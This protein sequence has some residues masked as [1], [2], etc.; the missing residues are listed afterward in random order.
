[1]K[2]NW[3]PLLSTNFLGVLNDNLLKY[4]VV[5][6][7]IGWLHESNSSMIVAIA[8]AM[9]VLPYIFFSPLAGYL[10]MKYD[11]ARIFVIM[12]LIEIPIALIGAVGFYYQNLY[13][14]MAA[15]LLIGLQSAIYS[16]SKYGLIRDVGGF[17]GIPY[18]TG[19]MEMLTFAGV[20][21]G[22]VLA[23]LVSDHYS[24]WFAA[25]L[26]VGIAVTGY[27]TSLKIKVKES[28][29]VELSDSSKNPY[30]FGVHTFKWSESTKGL[31]LIVFALSTFWL[32]GSLLQMNLVVHCPEHLG[33]TNIETGIVMAAAAIGIGLGCY[34]TG[35]LSN[36]K[37]ELG[38][39]PVGSIGMILTLGYIYIFDPKGYLFI[40]LIFIAAFFTGLYKVP[41]NSWIQDRVK[42]RMLGDILA[43]CNLLDFVFILVSAGIFAL[44][45]MIF[46]TQTVFIF[47]IV[48][49][50]LITTILF[51]YLPEMSERFKNLL[52]KK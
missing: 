1:M 12:K 8:S 21:I 5:F 31:N 13:V 24:I 40:A 14:A 52:S 35:I 22:T 28:A 7:G 33:M 46:D 34:L 47:I 39:V 25:G 30:T 19:A 18:G 42:G 38:F 17:E 9:L 6:V 20:L 50:A 45:S 26:L 32:I 11:K 44:M 48:I 51:I 3:F 23:S 27:I 49:M 29:P 10:A 2:T 16:P 41:L 15:V 37:V 36:H 4:L 43:Y